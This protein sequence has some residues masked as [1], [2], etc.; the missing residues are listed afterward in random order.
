M[1]CAYAILLSVALG[2]LYSVFPHYLIKGTIFEIK[3]AE[4]KMCVLIVSTTFVRNISH[5]EKN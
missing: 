5:C 4:H 3:F 1:Q 2:P